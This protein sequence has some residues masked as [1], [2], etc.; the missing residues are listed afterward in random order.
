M[1]WYVQIGDEQR[2]PISSNELRQ[3]AASGTVVGSTPIKNGQDGKWSTAS[4]V[5]GLQVDVTPPPIPVNETVPIS[6]KC[7]FCAEAI[8]AEAIKCKHCGEFLT[9][10]SKKA[11]DVLCS[12]E[13]S[14]DDLSH[15]VKCHKR[16]VVAFVAGFGLAV[17]PITPLA[18]S[19]AV[20]V[21]LVFAMIVRIWWAIEAFKVA[22][23]LYPRSYAKIL[24]V[25][26]I[27][28]PVP[29]SATIAMLI[30]QSRAVKIFEQNNIP[31]G[32]MGADLAATQTR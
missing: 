21:A 10:N 9:K 14:D 31:V 24:V 20:F 26:A 32:L 23:F 8:N 13:W 25:M 6:R 7:P 12:I 16:F 29:L 4:K 22:E 18:I 3:L 5:N 15:L 30:V 1:N 11:N 2:G 27:I 28:V 19:N 17:F